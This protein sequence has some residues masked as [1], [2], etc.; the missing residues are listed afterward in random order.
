MDQDFGVIELCGGPS[1]GIKFAV[2][3]PQF[4]EEWIAASIS[5]ADCF[6][7]CASGEIRVPLAKVKRF[8]Y[9]RTDRDTGDGARVYIFSRRLT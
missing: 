5:P 3:P 6:L 2:S 8:V 9:A 7:D 4:P 1:D